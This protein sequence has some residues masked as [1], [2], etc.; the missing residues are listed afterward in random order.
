ML[1]ESSK[2]GQSLEVLRNWVLTVRGFQ[3]L[4]QKLLKLGFKT[5]VTR[6]FNQDAL[7]FFFGLIRQHGVRNANPSCSAFGAY[8]KS[9]LVNNFL[10]SRNANRERDETAGLLATL[11]QFI[12]ETGVP[13]NLHHFEEHLFCVPED[14][15]SSVVVQPLQRYVIN[16]LAGYIAKMYFQI[17]RAVKPV[18][19]IYYIKVL[20]KINQSNQY[21]CELLDRVRAAYRTKSLQIE[22]TAGRTKAESAVC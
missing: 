4:R 5:F 11:K 17:Q 1:K 15:V 2:T 21:Y 3:L 12:T 16:Y 13:Q 7:E 6:A 10:I 14:L 18:Q 20:Q 22:L 9:L 8:H 19:I